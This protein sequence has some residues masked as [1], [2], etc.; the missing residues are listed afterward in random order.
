[1]SSHRS[2]SQ[3]LERRRRPLRLES[4]ELRLPLAASPFGTNPLQRLDVSRDGTLSPNDALI[5]INALAENRNAN[6]ADHIGN[7]IDPTGEGEVSPADILEVLN[8]LAQRE[9]ILAVTLPEDS[10]PISNDASAQ[11]LGFDLQTN[12]YALTIGLALGTLGDETVVLRIGDDSAETHEITDLFFNDKA[13]LTRELIDSFFGQPLPDGD[14]TV[15][16]EIADSNF[17]PIQFTLTVDRAVPELQDVFPKRSV[18]VGD[19]TIEIQMAS[20]G[21]NLFLDLDSVLLVDT[22]DPT[23][24]FRPSSIDVASRQSGFLVEFDQDIPAGD[25][26]VVVDE[27]RISTPT[28]NAVG[29]QIRRTPL[30]YLAPTAIWTNRA[31]G[32]WSDAENWQSGEIPGENDVVLIDVPEGVVV[33]GPFG[34]LTTIQHL[35]LRGVLQSPSNIQANTIAIDRGLMR[36]SG[37]GTSTDVLY[38]SRTGQGAIAV[39]DGT[40]RLDQAKVEL[41]IQVADRGDL[42]I[43]GGMRLDSTIQIMGSSSQQHAEVILDD[44]QQITGRGTFQFTGASSDAARITTRGEGFVDIADSMTIRGSRGQVDAAAS[45]PINIRATIIDDD[46][47]SDDSGERL[48]ELSGLG[49]DTGI[50]DLDLQTPVGLVQIDS[51]SGQTI[52]NRGTAPLQFRNRALLTDVTIE[53]PTLITDT[54]RL[55]DSVNLRSVV[56]LEGTSDRTARFSLEGSVNVDGDGEIVFAGTA[57]N[58]LQQRV[59]IVNRSGQFGQQTSVIGSDV[60]VRGDTGAVVGSLSSL[61]LDVL[62][63]VVGDAQSNIVLRYIG[64]SE[65]VKISSL[66]GTVA[67]DEPRPNLKITGIGDSVINVVDRQEWSAAQLSIDVNIH[68][69]AI[70]ELKSNATEGSTT[71][72]G[73]ITLLGN[74]SNRAQLL[75]TGVEPVAGEGAIVFAGEATRPF[76]NLFKADLQGQTLD[77]RITVR[78][79]NG[80]FGGR[81]IYTGA[82]TATD[83][84]TIGFGKLSGGGGSVTIDSR[85]GTVLIGEIENMVIDGVEDSGAIIHEFADLGFPGD[86]FDISTLGTNHVTNVTLN[87]PVQMLGGILIVA[88]GMEL[89][90]TLTLVGDPETEFRGDIQP[91]NSR[92]QFQ[93]SGDDKVVE[94][95]GSGSILFGPSINDPELEGH[96][97]GGANTSSL[98]VGPNVTLGGQNGTITS[99]VHAG[100]LI[101]EAGAAIELHHFT[102]S[103]GRIDLTP[104]S[105]RLYLQSVRDSVDNMVIDGTDGSVLYTTGISLNNATINIPLFLQ[106]LPGGNSTLGLGITVHGDLQLNSTLTLFDQGADL[107]F[108][109]EEGPIAERLSRI[110]GNGIIVMNIFDPNPDDDIVFQSHSLTSTNSLTIEAG[111]TIEAGKGTISSGNELRI[112]GTIIDQ[113][114]QLNIGDVIDE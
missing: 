73:T 83:G 85:D 60:T 39:E 62:G 49:S 5:V 91:Q 74:D 43:T 81:A 26:E 107:T 104:Q 1:M 35:T 6:P 67:I 46:R 21:D 17:E 31:G 16:I 103:P 96:I 36:I 99:T 2:R 32:R 22:T 7:F 3:R 20:S 19:R 109:N 15:R 68:P 47:P 102:T 57:S 40:M 8:G 55:H 97:I 59:D 79:R 82:I 53:S 98:S 45:N 23:R 89:N 77:S 34:N 106:N 87:L 105:G 4:L 52:R 112:R 80:L 38:T 71:I 94:L 18:L 100:P 48:I 37:G 114:G 11:G 29:D 54:L 50:V 86:G 113:H 42:W 9:P 56:T 10:S 95:T 70:L 110:F 90:S 72:G 41:P 12:D 88:E 51:L 93:N 30:S 25:Y 76:G 66:D 78:G 65:A 63:T 24:V 64:T 84:G 69:D 33:E 28:G 101:S 111:I 13:T 14:H 75:L 58:P 61:E 92:I 27:S 108:R 44:A